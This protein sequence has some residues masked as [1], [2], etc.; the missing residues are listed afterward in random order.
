VKWTKVKIGTYSQERCCLLV[1]RWVLNWRLKAASAGNWVE[2]GERQQNLYH[3]MCMNVMTWLAAARWIPTCG[4]LTSDSLTYPTGHMCIPYYYAGIFPNPPT[5]GL[6][7]QPTFNIPSKPET[8]NGFSV[9]PAPQ[10][11]CYTPKLK[12][13]EKSLLLWFINRPQIE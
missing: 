3:L 8:P 12:I 13:V 5:E 10:S 7:P 6:N 11:F 9:W 1:A 4:S 2:I